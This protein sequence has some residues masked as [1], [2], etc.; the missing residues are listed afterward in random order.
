MTTDFLRR[1]FIKKTGLLTSGLL[2]HSQMMDAFAAPAAA[3]KLKVGVIGCG[4]RGTGLLKIIND[5]PDKYEV[6][7]LCDEL[8]FRLTN[9]LKVKSA[10]KAKTYLDYRALLDSRQVEAVIIAVPLYLHFEVAKA[11]LLAGKQVYLEK[12]M[13]YDIPQALELVQLA[14]QRPNQTV[15]VGHQYRYSP[16]YYKV[17]EMIDKGYLGKVTQID[18][19][20][21]RNGSW[22]RHVPEPGL[23]R[24][25][26]WRM[27]R[28]YSGGLAAELLSHQIDFINWA[29]NTHA[30]ELFGTGGIDYYKDGRETYDNVQVMARYAK[31]GMVGNFGATCGNAYDG[32]LFKLKGTRGTISLL[33]DEGVY[34]PEKDT[35]KEY[36]TVDGV[37][38][39]TKITWDK[40]GGIPIQTG[41]LKDGSWYALNEFHRTVHEKKLPDSNVFTGAKVAC[42][43]HMANQAIYNRTIER[44]QPEYN[45]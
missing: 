45:V 36:G 29:F 42:T 27:Y 32:Y 41:P 40:N 13:T 39:A 10:A 4:D 6:T 20:W 23:E 26:N 37:T 30:D 16:L 7:A 24:K 22:R 12:T 1:D 31:E 28:E 35:L 33:I 44:W 38:G 2:L 43:V 11:S 9:A 34:Y 3:G 17:K 18:C 25:I 19:R 14:R 8:P 5:L 21:D 15:Q